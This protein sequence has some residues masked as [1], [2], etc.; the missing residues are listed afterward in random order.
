MLAV[1]GT[2]YIS[3]V[4]VAAADE[5]SLTP[6]HRLLPA[7]TA[8]LGA[9]L[10][11]VIKLPFCIFSAFLCGGGIITLGVRFMPLK[12]WTPAGHGDVFAVFMPP[13]NSPCVG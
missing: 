7:E 5:N 2:S 12:R 1:G 3:L 13:Q 4:S 11:E 10:G 8:S 9:L 6:L